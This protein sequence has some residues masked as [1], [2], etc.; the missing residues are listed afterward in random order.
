MFSLLGRS[1][2]AFARS[3]TNKE[4]TSPHLASCYY[5]VFYALINRYI[6]DYNENTYI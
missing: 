2:N 4:D 3:K 5:N 1:A 6:P